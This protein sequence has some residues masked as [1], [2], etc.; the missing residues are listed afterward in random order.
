MFV[1][2]LP[3][4]IYLCHNHKRES[5]SDRTLQQNSQHYETAKLVSPGQEHQ[6]LTRR[7]SCTQTVLEMASNPDGDPQFCEVFIKS[8]PMETEQQQSTTTSAPEEPKSFSFEAITKEELIIED[9]DDEGCNL[10]PKKESW[11]A[12]SPGRN[13]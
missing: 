13:H 12:L 10:R 1:K 4:F 6:Q 11:A 3:S 9:K 5:T 2:I 7:C 8:E